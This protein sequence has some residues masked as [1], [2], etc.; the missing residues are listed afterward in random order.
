MAGQRPDGRDD[1][2]VEERREQEGGH[3]PGRV[4]GD[5]QRVQQDRVD[6][7]ERRRTPATAR[8]RASSSAAASATG[9]CVSSAPDTGPGYAAC[10]AALRHLVRYLGR[11]RVARPRRRSRRDAKSG[12]GGDPTGPTTWRSTHMAT[13]QT[14]RA[15]GGR[16]LRR[17]RVR[18]PDAR[19]PRRAPALHAPDA[20]HR[21]ARDEPLPPGQG[22]RLVLRRLRP[23]GRVRGRRLRDVAAGP[24]VH[25]APRPRRAPHPRRHARR[26]SSPST[27]AAR[28][29]SPAAAT[30]TCTS[31]TTASA[32]S[33]WSRC[34][35]T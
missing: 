30:A 23:G 12:H 24:A 16:R 5:R 20:G 9:R 4:A 31:A 32:A 17:A 1:D 11:R 6:D 7:G 28:A 8:R 29:A 19:R 35:P 3:E 14:A 21:G 25:P 26:A 2:E 18:P 34:C 22:P 15:E 13:E 27:W 10:T 33:G